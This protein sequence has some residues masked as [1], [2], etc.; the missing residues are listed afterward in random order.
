MPSIRVDRSE[1]LSDQPVAITLEGFPPNGIVKVVSRRRD[2]MNNAWRGWARFRADSR[3]MIDVTTQTPVEGSYCCASP[4]GLFW[5]MELVEQRRPDDPIR[6]ITKPIAVRLEAR[7]LDGNGAAETE[8]R[9][10]LAAPGVTDRQL[11]ESG[12]V[13]RLFLPPGDGPHP[14]MIVL[15]GSSG[16][17]NLPVSALLASHGY[18]ALALGYFAMEGL[19]PTLDAIPLEYFGEA[20]AWLRRQAEVRDDAVGVTGTSRGGELAL[21]LGATFPEIRAVVAY[22]PSGV[23]HS[24]LT[25]SSDGGGHGSGS[26]DARAGE[27]R[28]PWATPSS[29]R[30]T[31]TRTAAL[32][33][34]LDHGGQRGGE[35][36]ERASG[37]ADNADT[38]LYRDGELADEGS[39]ED[40]CGD[41]ADQAD[42]AAASS[43]R[44]F[45]RHARELA[46]VE[47]RL[48]DEAQHAV[49]YRVAVAV[50]DGLEVVYVQQQHGKLLLA[51]DGLLQRLVEGL[52]VVEAGQRVYGLFT[53]FRF[54]FLL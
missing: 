35:H 24:G 7:A 15:S 14:A 41:D 50:V 34:D 47:R 40:E 51:V 1:T 31:S 30:A 17:I 38:T 53:P 19:P 16:G 43:E 28:G 45:R 33:D 4:M 29:A 32:D 5:S 48:A 23:I 49:S 44:D 42:E 21:L 6:D 11:R 12:K 36:A 52:A 26:E 8:I 22:V 13:G 10:R 9:R 27:G 46:A 39:E 54:Q 37:K 25:R 18:A 3:G 2:L 20:I